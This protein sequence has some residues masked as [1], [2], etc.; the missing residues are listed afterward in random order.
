MLLTSGFR[1]YRFLPT[2]WREFHP[3]FD[4]PTPPE[5][6]R[7]LNFLATGQYREAF[8][9]HTGIVRFSRPQC[10]R[11]ALRSIPEGR[12]DDAHVAYYLARNPGHVVGDE[13]VC[14]TEIREANLTPAGR[15]MTRS[16]GR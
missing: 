10:L 6:H 8:N 5:K 9:P 15:R 2:F 12:A 11:G 4:S 14:L 13:L 7:L 16:T 3:R 1:T